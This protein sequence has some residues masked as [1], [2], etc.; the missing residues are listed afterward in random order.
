[1]LNRKFGANTHNYLHV[2]GLSGLAFGLPLN[3]VVMSLSMMF[4]VMNLLLEG[5]FKT[6]WS[7]IKSNRGFL[8]I[9]SFFLL[10]VISM[11]WST[12]MEYG[13]HD[14]KAKLP[15]FIVPLTLVAKPILDKKP[16]NIILFSFLASVTLTSFINFGAYNQWFGTMEFDDI[17]GMSLFSSHVR[18]GL[19]IVMAVGILIHLFVKKQIPFILLLPLFI[20]LNF[21]T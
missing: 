8:L 9:F 3:K 2:L 20:W 18:Y 14:L 4:L 6:Y 7:H 16:L 11:L 19:L 5:N 1:M 15:L 21:Y 17:R 13:I 10:H 12:D